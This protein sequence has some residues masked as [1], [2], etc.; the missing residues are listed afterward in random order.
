MSIA[1]NKTIDTTEKDSLATLPPSLA[2]FQA[3]H[4]A[5]LGRILADTAHFDRRLLEVVRHFLRTFADAGKLCIR[6]RERDLSAIL[7][8]DRVKE[9]V[10]LGHGTTNGGPTTRKEVIAAAFDADVENLA[11]DQFPKY[12][13]LGPDSAMIDMVQC[14]DLGYHY[15]N[16]RLVLR[17]ETMAAR[18]TLSMGDGVNF[19]CFYFKVPTWLEHPEPTCFLSLPHH[20]DLMISREFVKKGPARPEMA[21]AMFA[22][23]CLKGMLTKENFHEIGDVF[24]GANGFEFFEL[25]YHGHLVVSRDV[26]RVDIFQWTDD[27]PE[28]FNSVKPRFERLGIPCNLV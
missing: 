13:Y 12:G 21:M 27:T 19:G 11:P 7:D 9:M 15:G 6:V 1:M 16:V 14:S 24:E 3:F 20:V 17:R 25:H 22:A 23:A 8:D 26:E 5:Y 2:R 18:T 28:I 4:D 10:E